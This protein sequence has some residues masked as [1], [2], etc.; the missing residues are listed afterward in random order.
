MERYRVISASGTVIS[1]RA[2]LDLA[3]AICVRFPGSTIEPLAQTSTPAADAQH[4]A[5]VAEVSTPAHFTLT[6]RGPGASI[7]QSDDEIEMTA[8]PAPTKEPET[9]ISVPTFEELVAALDNLMSAADA[10][11]GGCEW[12]DAFTKA[13][14]KANE[15]LARCQEAK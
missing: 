8:T 7:L 9:M 5:Y 6:Y 4:A 1:A 15:L 14:Y 13:A 2:P 3:K 12:S 10:S 11:W